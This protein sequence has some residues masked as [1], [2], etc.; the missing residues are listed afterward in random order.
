M[1]P[2]AMP[3]LAP[4]DMEEVVDLVEGEANEAEE[5]DKGEELDWEEVDVGVLDAWEL[6]LLEDWEL[7]VE[8]VVV[9]EEEVP[10]VEE[11]GRSATTVGE[12]VEAA[13]VEVAVVML[14]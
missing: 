6:E 11:V 10:V 7:E 13:E 8:D 5:V 14:K 2:T 12:V 1:E 3:I 4:V 9:D